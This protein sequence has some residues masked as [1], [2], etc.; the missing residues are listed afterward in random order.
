MRRTWYNTVGLLA[1][2]V[3]ITFE[4]GRY[5]GRKA[6]SKSRRDREKVEAKPQ[7]FAEIVG[8][9]GKSLLKIPLRD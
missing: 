7:R 6:E 8:D 1:L 3:T 2:L 9:D 4:F 5:C